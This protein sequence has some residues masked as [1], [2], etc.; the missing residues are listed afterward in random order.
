MVSQTSGGEKM[1]TY[2]CSGIVPDF[3]AMDNDL[4][5]SDYTY[6]EENEEENNEEN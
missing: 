6:E 2:S 1:I 3:L 5:D 4:D